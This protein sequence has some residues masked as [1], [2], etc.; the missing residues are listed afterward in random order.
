[1]SLKIPLHAASKREIILQSAE[2]L[3]LE[4]Y[5]QE[6]NGCLPSKTQS[7]VQVYEILQEITSR[8][9]KVVVFGF[10][11]M[12][13]D[14]FY[15]SMLP[16]ASSRAK[17]APLTSIF[18]SNTAC[19]WS[20]I[21]TGCW[22]AEHGVYGTSFRLE[23]AEQNYI[24]IN[25]TLSHGESRQVVDGPVRLNVSG[26]PTLLTQLKQDGWETY[27]NGNHGYGE[28]NPLRAELTKDTDHFV[29]EDYAALKYK[30]QQ[31]IDCFLSRTR[32]LLDKPGSK[33]IIWN[34]YNLDDFIHEHGYDELQKAVDWG[35]FFAFWQDL[36]GK[37]TAILLT[38][39]HGQTPQRQSALNWL[40]ITEN[41]PWFAANT[42][43]AGRT[44]YFYPK[45]E[46]LDQ[47]YRW[48]KDNMGEDAVVLT[49][50]EAF[51]RGLFVKEI[52]EASRQ[53]RIGDIIAVAKTDMFVS[54]GSEYVSEHGALTQHEMI[55]PLMIEEG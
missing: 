51:D 18:P 29:P 26:K 2:Q 6:F 38:A 7:I 50:K 24:W 54:A 41:H 3:Y 23:G 19:G 43:G 4:N 44:L 53:E 31:L 42:G 30:P 22:P 47:A 15:K 28:Y 9:G 21:L 37:D 12:S 48:L 14:F 55:V 5:V 11:A 20:S 32:K 46:H 10:D 52:Q 25:N 36:I 49:R 45:P 16:F 39:D 17:V 33:K 8:K 40:R 34:Y 1:M 13:F 35:A 27:Y